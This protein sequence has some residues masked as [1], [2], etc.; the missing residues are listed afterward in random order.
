MDSR[1]DDSSVTLDVGDIEAG[2]Q[3]IIVLLSYVTMFDHVW[4]QAFRRRGPGKGVIITGQPGIGVL[5]FPP[6]LSR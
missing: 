1:L 6:S 3:S 5:T 2:I 4:A